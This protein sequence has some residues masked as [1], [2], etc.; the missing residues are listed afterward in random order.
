[1]TKEIFDLTTGKKLINMK[2]TKRK[3]FHVLDDG[4]MVSYMKPSKLERFKSKIKN[5]LN[6]FFDL[7]EE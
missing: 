6:Y 5:N 2:E 3:T 4:S 1:M 7:N